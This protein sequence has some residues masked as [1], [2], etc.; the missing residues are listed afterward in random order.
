VPA[1]LRGWVSTAPVHCAA[2]AGAYEELVSNLVEALRPIEVELAEAWWEASTHASDD[3]N[4]RKAELELARRQLLADP[5]GFAAVQAAREALDVDAAVRRHLDLLH[6]AMVPNQVPEDLQRRIVELE[7]E[8]EGTFTSFRGDLNGERVADNTI[9]EILRTSDDRDQRRRAWEASKQVGAAVAGSVR[10]L[11]RLRNDAARSVGYRDHFAMALGVGEMD[12]DR[13][14]ATLDEVDQHTEAPFVAWKERLDGFLADR[15]GIAVE[16]L[17]PWHLDDPFFQDPP[18]AGAVDL[19]TRFADAD[20][21]ALTVRTY[22]GLGLDV[23]PVLARSDLYG[24]EGKNQHA[25]CI[26]IDREGDVRVLCN[27]EPS[28]R[29]MDTMLHEFGHAVYNQGVAP[30]LPW[31]VRDAAHPLTTEGVAMLFGRLVRSPDWLD[32]VAGV[33]PSELETLR[34]RLAEA[35]RASLLVFARWV[36]VVTHFERRLYADPDGD[37]DSVWWDLVERYQRVRRP[38]GRAAPDWA[39]KIHLAVVPVYYQNYLYGELF[40]SQLE[41]TLAARAGGFVDRRGAGRF[42]AESVFA[43]GASRRWDQLV[44]DATGEP[45]SAAHLAKQL[46]A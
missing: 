6:D 31:L 28:E 40:A 24:R 42:L 12:E 32:Q 39:S 10:A 44:R 35:R 33:P 26:D 22:D 30:T 11:A 23:R 37:L 8:V 16:D 2:V 3:A 17:A 15:F 45:L 38:A 25:F 7:T 41:S 19:D 43:P 29:W 46:V 4:R 9:L 34:P 13:L 5:D 27:V 18:T 1:T 21:E 20:L 36:L 14:L